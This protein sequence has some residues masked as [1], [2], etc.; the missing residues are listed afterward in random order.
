MRRS[1]AALF[2][3]LWAFLLV[4]P[5]SANSAAWVDSLRAGIYP[6]LKSW[7]PVKVSP[8]PMNTI[9]EPGTV[10]VLQADGVS[11]AKL[12]DGY[13]ANTI[14]DGAISQQ[15]SSMDEVVLGKVDRRDFKV[16]D[17]FYLAKYEIKD[18]QI[19][20]DLVS[21]GTY[22]VT[23]NGATKA[24]R[25]G[26]R[27]RFEFP[28]GYLPTARP[29]EVQ[30]AMA[31]VIMPEEWMKNAPPATVELGQTFEQVEKALGKPSRIVNLGTKVTWIYDDMK[32]IFADSKV[33]DVQ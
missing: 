6:G 9:L 8:R 27:L 14:R 22:D 11:G 33:V 10:L 3:G 19:L 2:M 7:K 31:A 12:T 26:V 17:K 16:G 1:A 21:C 13:G 15:G 32:V 4:H 24:E 18:R 30:A 20:Y 28:K 29:A 5:A 25:Y 23:T